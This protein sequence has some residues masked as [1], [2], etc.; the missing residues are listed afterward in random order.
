MIRKSPDKLRIVCWSCWIF[1]WRFESPWECPHFPVIGLPA[2]DSK[3]RQ[4]G[5][6]VPPCSFGEVLA[7]TVVPARHRR[8]NGFCALAAWSTQERCLLE[9]SH[10]TNCLSKILT[11]S[12]CLAWL[13]CRFWITLPHSYSKSWLKL[14][15]KYGSGWIIVRE[16]Y[17]SGWKN[18]PNMG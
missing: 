8:R 3:D 4:T 6:A 10:L 14:A 15:K 13:L 1:S 9:L 12:R 5:G 16:K 7:S 18:K 11:F 2:T 17:C